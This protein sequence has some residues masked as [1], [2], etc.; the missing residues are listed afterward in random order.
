MFL[1]G[2]IYLETCIRNPA[3]VPSSF[4]KSLLVR[5]IKLK[6]K[7]G[8]FL[9]LPIRNWLVILMQKHTVFLGNIWYEN[10]KKKDSKTTLICGNF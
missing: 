7:H 1:T 5:C 8:N 2:V 9:H 3:D 4:K 10:F 6:V